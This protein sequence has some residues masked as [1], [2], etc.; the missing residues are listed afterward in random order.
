MDPSRYI[1]MSLKDRQ[2]NVVRSKKSRSILEAR[3]AFKCLKV[4]C[5]RLIFILVFLRV[6]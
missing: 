6:F 5:R 1:K 2:N 3:L 4:V